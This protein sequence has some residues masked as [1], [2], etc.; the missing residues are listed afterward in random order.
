MTDSGGNRALKSVHR[1]TI[2][3]VLKHS[4]NSLTLPPWHID[5]CGEYIF[6][7]GLLLLGHIFDVDIDVA[8]FGDHAFPCIAP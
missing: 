4:N 1:N 2:I 8:S 3:R 6:D 7:E 5:G